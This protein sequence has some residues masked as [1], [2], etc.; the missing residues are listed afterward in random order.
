MKMDLLHMVYQLLMMIGYEL[1]L[2]FLDTMLTNTTLNNHQSVLNGMVSQWTSHL[3]PP[4]F[5][6]SDTNTFIPT[7]SQVIDI[8]KG[9]IE[10]QVLKVIQELY[11]H[12]GN[13]STVKLERISGALTN[14]VFFVTL[15]SHQRLVLRVYGSGCDQLLDRNKE[16]LWLARLTPLKMGA[17]LLG[18][19]ANGRF[20]EYLYSTTLTHACLRDPDTSVIIAILLARLHAIVQL[21][22]PSSSSP[23]S[24]NPDLEI[25]SQI[26]KWYDALL[27]E[28]NDGSSFSPRK[29]LAGITLKK[30]KACQQWMDQVQS[31]IVFAHNDLQYGNILR[32]TSTN[33]LVAVDF[34]YAGYNSRGYDLANH[35]MEWQYNYHGDRPA[36]ASSQDAPTRQ[37]QIRFVKAYLAHH[38]L[39]SSTTVDQLLYE[40]DCWT[41]V[42]HLGWGLW[43]LVQAQQ[44]D[45]DFDYLSYSCQRLNMFCEALGRMDP[46]L[47]D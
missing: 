41:T 23:L 34:E 28:K 9:N 19:F 46:S 5:I 44:S 7:A 32:L 25:W 14:A 18:T 8:S 33:E 15:P 47:L 29:A 22:P 43:G 26:H 39:K 6:N 2:R 10:K 37:Q 4:P 13:I 24:S 17:R 30:I 3:P 21:H 42:C 16:L 36:L 20:E 11:P 35:F 40:I 38:H 12:L 1:Q 31:P 27:V 45:I